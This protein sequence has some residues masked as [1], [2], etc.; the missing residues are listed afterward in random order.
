VS[1][2]PEPP[3]QPAAGP[4]RPA[5]VVLALGSNLGDRMANLQSAVDALSGPPGLEFLAVSPVYETAPVCG[6]SQPD[7][8]NAVLVASTLLPPRAVL[9]RCQ[10]AEAARHRDRV[11]TWGPRTLDVDVIAYD[12]VIS[13]DPVLTLPH[14]RAH[15]RAFV[16]APWH[17]VDPG[18]QLPGR[19]KVADLLG[20]VTSATSAAGAEPAAVRRVP[21]ILRRPS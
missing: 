20:A 12:D 16:L 21:G 17:D 11:V 6:P 4:A 13:D 18:A 3:V 7:F 1:T 8:L 2:A 10:G 19:G 9:N 5:R 15:E 14:P